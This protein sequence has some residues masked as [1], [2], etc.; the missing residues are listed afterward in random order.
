MIQKRLG[1][2]AE[3][4]NAWLKLVSKQKLQHVINPNGTVTGRATHHSPNLAQVP[5]VRA[6]YGPE[7]RELFTVPDG[8]ELVGS[9]LSG[10]ELRCLAHFMQ[11]GGQ[12]A[13]EILN[14]DIHTANQ[15]A[16][17]LE[18]RDQAKTAIYCLIYGGGDARLGEVTGAGAAGGRALRERFMQAQPAYASL[19]R[20]VKSAFKSKGH[21]LGLDGR[22]LYIRSEHAALNTLLQ[23]AG[24]LICKKWLELINDEIEAQGIDAQIIAWVHDECQI[25]VRKGQGENVGRI[26]R[27][28]ASKAGEYFQI[29]IPIDAEYRVGNNWRAT[30]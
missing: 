14:G 16:M 4:R 7:C 13:N 18:T 6:E 17:G 1:Q 25:M 3:G 2:L 10:L 20:A 24:A 29:K 8:Y 30:H 22:K 11:D 28:M 9:D 27:S 12:Y 5:S 19:I 26:S 15:K 23:S 21:L